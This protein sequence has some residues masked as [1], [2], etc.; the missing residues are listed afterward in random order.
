MWSESHASRIVSAINIYDT[1]ERSA[2]KIHRRV[3]VSC[4]RAKGWNFCG[5]LTFCS[6]PF[7]EKLSPL[8]ALRNHGDRWGKLRRVRTQESHPAASLRWLARKNFFWPIRSRQFKRFWNWFGKSKCPGA[9]LDR[10]VNF[11]HEHFIDPTNCPWVSEDERPIYWPKKTHGKFGN[12]CTDEAC[13]RSF[14][15]PV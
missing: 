1:L 11:Q 13:N 2:L 6:E 12:G 3:F 5:L 15:F 14:R 9:R 10:T 7:L 4:S 8:N